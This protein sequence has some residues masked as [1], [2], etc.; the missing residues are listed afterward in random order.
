MD[1]LADG[2]SLW[3]YRKNHLWKLDQHEV[4]GLRRV[5]ASANLMENPMTTGTCWTVAED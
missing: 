1:K 2:S 4:S 5:L 3:I